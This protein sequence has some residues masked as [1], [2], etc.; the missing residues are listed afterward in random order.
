M[1]V[2]DGETTVYPDMVVLDEENGSV[3]MIGEVE[4]ASSVTTDEA[5][6]WRQYGSMSQAFYLYVPHGFAEQAR[7]L[8]RGLRLTGI[9]TF[10]VGADGANLITNV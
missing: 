2:T 5:D 6:Q 8:T 10:G 7:Q 1:G 4:T 9:R 3:V